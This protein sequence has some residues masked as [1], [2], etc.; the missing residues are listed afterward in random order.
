M[1]YP[2]QKP[3]LVVVWVSDYPRGSKVDVVAVDDSLCS[4]DVMLYRE[5]EGI[6]SF[7]YEYGVVV[8]E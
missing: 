7:E 2:R 8:S 3:P 4:S 1:E 6:L 5:R